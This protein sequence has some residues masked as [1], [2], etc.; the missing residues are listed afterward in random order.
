MTDRA[1]QQLKAARALAEF[2]Y[3]FNEEGK[4]RQLDAHT[5]AITDKGFEFA[6]YKE[7]KENQKRYEQIGE[8]ITDYVYERLEAVGM[9]RL[10]VPVDPAPPL[11]TFVFSTAKEL[12]RP[13]KLL[14][15]IHG[16][17]VVKAGQWSRSLI[18]NHS[19]AAGTQLPYIESA[20]KQG[21]EILVTNTNDNIVN[22]KPIPGSEDSVEHAVYVW[23]KYVL[24]A[25]PKSVAIVAHS[26]GGIVTLALARKYPVFF[27]EKVFAIGL[28][29]SVHLGIKGCTKEF[30]DY[31][32]SISRNWVRSEKPLDTKL[33]T[34][35]PDDVPHYSAGHMQHEWTSHTCMSALFDFFR[36][37]HEA[38]QRAQK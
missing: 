9:E 28:T 8:V 37:R 11:S 33:A 36:E 13:E 26:Y 22:G 32:K 16:S 24:P 5:G 34:G 18:I 6:M 15:L 30:R 2:G 19:I 38:F 25:N 12:N 3:G 27:K 29:D 1:P 23:E 31:I 21:F 4:L 7:H 14:L 20:R 10:P 35:D 17:G